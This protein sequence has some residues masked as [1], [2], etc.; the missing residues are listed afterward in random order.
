[1]KNKYQFRVFLSPKTEVYDVAYGLADGSSTIYRNL[2]LIPKLSA[3]L[4]DDDFELLVKELTQILDIGAIESG[5]VRKLRYS[6]SV[7]AKI[8]VD[9]FKNLDV[10]QYLPKNNSNA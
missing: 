2:K 8:A 9:E 7:K 1:M 10:S 5:R 6:A 4:S 3:T